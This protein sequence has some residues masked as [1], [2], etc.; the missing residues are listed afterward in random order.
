MPPEKMS[1]DSIVEVAVFAAVSHT[2]HYRVPAEL[3]RHARIGKRVLVP[4]ARQQALGLLVGFEQPPLL[5]TEGTFLRDVLAMVDSSPTV[6]QE[7]IDLCRWVAD[8]YFYPLG[9][10]L[11]STLPGNIQLKPKDLLGITAAGK[12]APDSGNPSGLLALLRNDSPLSLAEIQ[13]R[14][15]LPKPPHAEI[16]A[17]LARGWL[18]RIFVWPDP[19]AR[20]RVVNTVRLCDGGHPLL[21]SPLSEKAQKLAT[22][23]KQASGAVP[24]R[25]ILDQIKG[26]KYWLDKWKH[27]GVIAIEA[28]EMPRPLQ[29]VKSIPA[30]PT[31]ILNADQESAVEAIV[32]FLRQPSFC[33]FL[34]HGVTGSGKTEVYL[35]L[36]EEA[37]QAG[38]GVLTL[39]PEIAL[40]TQ[41]EGLFRHRLGDSLTIWHSALSPSERFDQWRRALNRPTGV[42]LGARSAVFMPIQNLGLIIVDEEH[43]SSYKQEDRLRYQA[44]DVAL[45]RARRLGIPILLGSATPSLQSLHHALAGRYRMLTLS[46]RIM[47]RPLP[48][49]EV[50]DMRMQRGK[51]RI[52]STTLQEALK[53]TVGSG[54]QAILFLNRRGFAAF[55]LCRT[56]GEALPCP[57]CSVSLTYHRQRDLLSCHYC[58]HEQRPPET[59]PRCGHVRLVYHGFGTERVE[60]E[61]RDLLPGV[62]L[63]RM[64]RD[65][66]THSRELVRI[67]DRMH[68]GQVDVLL[69]TQMVAKG[70]DFPNVTLVGVINADISLQMADFRAGETTVQL[71]MQVAGRAGRGEDP[72]HVIIQSYNPR[73]P[74]I[75]CALN[76]DYLN[77][78]GQELESR[79][80]LQYPPFT[81]LAKILVTDRDPEIARQAAHEL[82]R[83]G[84]ELVGRMAAHRQSL[85]IMGPAPAPLSKLKN[86]YRWQIYVKAWNSRDLQE[87][88][89]SLLIQ[90]RDAALLR[91]AQLSVDRDPMSTL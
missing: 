4:L 65:T 77:F 69:G 51:A 34:I 12:A 49:I 33:P 47:E 26:A 43:D 13:G 82:A 81:R 17:L 85:V 86:R 83:F 53:Q 18:E 2:L 41:L 52:L 73:H 68:G 5:V 67:L 19:P 30:I 16:K 31:P 79:R 50:V 54:Q 46:S 64:D 6:P 22:L 23:L 35:R 78:A 62:H 15:Q 14:L 7:L 25:E 36:I 42:V 37:L 63:A 38:R 28:L 87:F 89:G 9:E 80:N 66:I 20:L 61:L 60:Q 71:L 24:L 21:A 1:S 55:L 27:A 39:V 3:R 72:G 84:H 11:Q 8:Y 91:R 32:P 45:V 40:S 74:A 90:A 59:C 70:H 29:C 76:G 56:C 58:G 88:V 57:H 44:R 48:T 75:Q 10:V